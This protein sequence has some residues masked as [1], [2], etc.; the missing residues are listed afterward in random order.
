MNLWR[1]GEDPT[2]ELTAVI[3]ISHAA[4]LIC[5][6]CDPEWS[7]DGATIPIFAGMILLRSLDSTLE[8]VISQIPRDRKK[9]KQFLYSYMDAQLLYAIHH[10]HVASDWEE[11]LAAAGK[12]GTQLLQQLYTLY[13]G[14]VLDMQCGKREAAFAKAGEIAE[15]YPRRSKL[16]WDDRGGGP[17]N[18]YM[19]D[20]VLAALLRYFNF[21]EQAQQDELLRTHLWVWPSP[22]SPADPP[23]VS[24]DSPAEWINRALDFQDGP[25]LAHKGAYGFC[26]RLK[27]FLHNGEPIISAVT[28]GEKAVLRVNGNSAPLEPKLVDSML[29]HLR[30]FG[31]LELKNFAPRVAAPGDSTSIDL[32]M[33]DQTGRLHKLGIHAAELHPDKRAIIV[34]SCIKKWLAQA[35]GA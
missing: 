24:T 21:D 4:G 26:C 27:H 6:E 22:T 12:R 31:A 35:Q 7:C 5:R 17:E 29:N 13:M 14:V 15:L 25:I 16:G 10:G 19:V 9:S 20:I 11:S 34:A 32:L 2:N 3:E 23:K 8:A 28:N 30:A 33:K 1:L 18:A